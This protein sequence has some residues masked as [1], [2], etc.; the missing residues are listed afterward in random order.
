MATPRSEKQTEQRR[1]Y[2]SQ[3][4]AANY[5]SAREKHSCSSELR[6]LSSYASAGSPPKDGA[7]EGRFFWARPGPRQSSGRSTDR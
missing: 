6:R 1:R 5:K 2:S 7:K 4:G 3:P